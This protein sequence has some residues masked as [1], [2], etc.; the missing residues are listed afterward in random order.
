MTRAA[1]R[2]RRRTRAVPPRRPGTSRA[3]V[4]PG[5][6]GNAGMRH[7]IR[8]DP[9][10]GDEVRLSAHTLRGLCTALGVNRA[11]LSS[12]EFS[13]ALA[14]PCAVW[15]HVLEPRSFSIWGR[16]QSV[17]P[18]L[19]E[20]A[21]GVRRGL[22]VPS[23]ESSDKPHPDPC[24]ILGSPHRAQVIPQMDDSSRSVHAS[25]GSTAWGKTRAWR[26]G[27]RGA[28]ACVGFGCARTAELRHGIRL[29]PQMGDDSN[30]SVHA[31]RSSCTAPA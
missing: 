25:R 14:D 1:A 19:A 13:C 10:M 31:S 20:L 23:E 2:A 21:H 27:L 29:I 16:S 26:T 18:R 5:S 6:V 30:R 11:G 22:L 7:G 24:A 8:L 3:R 9:H 15:G 28:L 12:E 4:A 17:H